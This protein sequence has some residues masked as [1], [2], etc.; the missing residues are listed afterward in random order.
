MHNLA[1]KLASLHQ[2]PRFNTHTLLSTYQ[3]ERKQI[4]LI[5]SAQSVKNGLTIFSFLKRLGATDPDVSI[6]KKKLFAKVRS[7][8]DADRREIEEGIE[9]QRE[10]FDNH[11]LH[12]GYVYGDMK[13]PD[14]ASVYKRRF[15]AGAR[16]PHVWLKAK[17]SVDWFDELGLPPIDSS[18]VDEFSV[19]QVKEREWSVLDLC[20]FDAFTLFAPGG[21]VGRRWQEILVDARVA[22]PASLKVNVAVLDQDFELLNGNYGDEWKQEMGL[23]DGGAVL[24][25]P[26][27][28]ILAILSTQTTADMFGQ[29]IERHLG[30]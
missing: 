18:Y 13:I 5:N 16:L 24:V 1:W 11:G 17:P 19:E 30:L 21:Q 28:H 6:A 25:R 7:Q 8:H 15:V 9:G 22:L 3:S 20:A 12:I 4:A 29:A 27:Q 10:H 23:N 2:H 14:H 26:D